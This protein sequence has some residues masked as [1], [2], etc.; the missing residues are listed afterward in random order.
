M[1]KIHNFL[2]KFISVIL[3]ISLL[4]LATIEAA[5][6][7]KVY[8]MEGTKEPLVESEIHEGV[9]AE[10]QME[11]EGPEVQGEEAEVQVM[12]EDMEEEEQELPAEVSKTIIEIPNR[13]VLEIEEQVDS[14]AEIV[15]QELMGISDESENEELIELYLSVYWEEEGVDLYW[16]EYHEVALY[17][18]YRD[19]I[20][21]TSFSVDTE[22]VS[23]YCDTDVQAGKQYSYRVEGKNENGQR[24]T[25]TED[26]RIPRDLV[27]DGYE[28][29]LSHDETVYSVNVSDGTIDL[30]GYTLTVYSDIVMSD[31]MMDNSDYY[32][33][34]ISCGGNL[35]LT[36]SDITYDV[37]MEL[38]G[39]MVVT[40]GAIRMESLVL[41]GTQKQTVDIAG[42]SSIGKI[43]LKNFSEE[44]V[45]FASPV[46]YG[47]LMKNDCRFT[48]EEEGEYGYTLQA[49]VIYEGDYHLISGGLNL[50]GHTM[51]VRGDFYH[52]KGCC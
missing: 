45:H 30:N 47:K 51:T 18:V 1:K 44:G 4:P 37:S 35:L 3:I 9:N 17:E 36:E 46:S 34:L 32:N 12:Q 19:N 26:V 27:V 13:E 42:E 7:N 22:H 14:V 25:R 6:D 31:G 41:N 8:A 39:S 48:H 2:M 16:G 15:E 33:G 23:S 50:N 21:L 5:L 20:L 49:D 52:L 29:R 38:G 10:A 28:Y 40:G 43:E 24:I 11:E